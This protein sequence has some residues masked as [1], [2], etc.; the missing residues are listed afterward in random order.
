ML[1]VVFGKRV[2]LIIVLDMVARLGFDIT[3]RYICNFVISSRPVRRIQVSQL[4]SNVL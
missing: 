1:E 3:Y 2:Q 4:L